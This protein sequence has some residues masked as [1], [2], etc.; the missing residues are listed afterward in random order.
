MDAYWQFPDRVV[1]FTALRRSLA[2]DVCSMLR[3]YRFLEMRGLINAR[4]SAV[5]LPP[6]PP[7][8]TLSIAPPPPAAAQAKDDAAAAAVA[9]WTEEEMA[10][11]LAAV[12]RYGDD[13]NTVSQQVGRSA[14]ECLL[15][16][17]RMP[18]AAG[19]SQPA[20]GFATL[21]SITEDPTAIL[22]LLS[23]VLPAEVT[24]SAARSATASSAQDA[25]SV[26]AA[27]LAGASKQAAALAENEA[28]KLSANLARAVELLLKSLEM[29]MARF[30]EL[31]AH[32]AKRRETLR[33]DTLKHLVESTKKKE[34]E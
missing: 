22:S 13:W 8:T 15:R 4:V 23:Q 7:P 34:T 20:G 6:A 14:L 30:S 19:R 24:A 17:V 9:G 27:A 2:G 10:R 32:I 31:E 5:S 11:L 33:E 28:A 21:G 26:A 16:F 3:L 29:R 12:E 1:S 18:T 25:R